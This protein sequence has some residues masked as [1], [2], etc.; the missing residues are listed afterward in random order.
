M[1]GLIIDTSGSHALLALTQGEEVTTTSIMESGRGLSGRLFMELE[2]LIGPHIKD[3]AYI[4]TG[5]GP[6]SFAGTRTAVTIAKTLAFS[7]GLP[8]IGF[9]S[10][11]AFIP[12]YIEKGHFAFLLD[13][14]M[15]QLALL[16]GHLPSFEI[17]T[18]LFKKD[19]IESHLL[20]E[21]PI[22]TDLQISNH[23]HLPEPN[24]SRIAKW[25]ANSPP[26]N[27]LNIAYLQSID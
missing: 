26:S 16:T 21:C 22:I 1:S 10:P 8:L 14:K 12:P 23:S 2:R 18:T 19:E 5:T 25:V 6:G 13:A 4:A 27:S 24:L 20:M 3:L 17:T 9:P 11:L 7:T 15:G